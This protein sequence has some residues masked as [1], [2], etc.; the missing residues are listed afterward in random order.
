MNVAVIDEMI[1]EAVDQLQGVRNKV[2]FVR[3]VQ[4]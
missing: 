4:E 1:P 3:G 2:N